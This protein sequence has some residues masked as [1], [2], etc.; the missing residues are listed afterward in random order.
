MVCIPVNDQRSMGLW[1]LMLLLCLSACG[2]SRPKPLFLGVQLVTDLVAQKEFASIEVKLD[3]R[4]VKRKKAE[5][6]GYLSPERVA[7]FEGLKANSD[8]QISVRLLDADGKEVLSRRV[9]L[10]HKEST[11]RTVTLTRSCVG[12]RCE[13]QS[14]SCLGGSCLDPRCM[15][16]SE[17]A[18]GEPLCKSDADCRPTSGCDAAVCSF[19]ACLV[20]PTDQVCDAGMDA[21]LTDA[22]ARDAAVD[23]GKDSG[24]NDAGRDAGDDGPLRC[25][26]GICRLD[27]ACASF[28]IDTHRYWLCE[29]RQT[30]EA[31][32]MFCAADGAHL[33]IIDNEPESTAI[34]ARIALVTG[35]NTLASQ[36]FI[37]IDDL[38][39]QG[40][41][42]WIDGSPLTYQNW[43]PGEPNNKQSMVCEHEDCGTIF[44]AGQWNDACCVSK[45][46]FVCEA[47]LP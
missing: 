31:A 6:A 28:S 34:G 30:Y 37:G 35:V 16:G 36:H 1:S 2:D 14:E 42:V 43:R 10:D 11:T 4:Q 23:A 39:T 12:V 40:T 33:A 26:G 9:Q 3:D 20:T 5:A 38:T 27:A 45:L 21:G 32:K 19:G 13:A 8:R 18:C 44:S 15:D 17:A 22:G 47:D 25:D 29:L 41:Y 24:V 46:P 7:D